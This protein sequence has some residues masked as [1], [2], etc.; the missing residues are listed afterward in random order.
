VWGGVAGAPYYTNLYAL[1][2]LTS[3]NGTVL[4]NSWREFLLQL[5]SIT[6]SGMTAQIDSELLEFD[7]TNGTVTGTGT[8]AQPLQTM[9]G[10]GNQLP[11]STQAL[12]QWSTN[13]IVH[14]RRVRGRT[15]IP[16]VL[17]A[18][19]SPTGNPLPGVGTPLQSAVD[20]FLSTMSGRL[21]VWSREV[22]AE[23]AT[24]TVPA[25]L[26]SAHAISAGKVAPYWAVLR[27]R[28]D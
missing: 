25:R 13:G 12:I 7:E 10:L 5:S 15:F 9:T 24:P 21:R 20:T 16:G 19:N 3:N 17:V 18:H 6:A 1:G 23:N 22:K 27:S 2:P 28:R 4:S 26:G 11:H 14:N 8:L